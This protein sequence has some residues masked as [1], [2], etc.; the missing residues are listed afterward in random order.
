[1]S[2]TTS[3]NLFD[4]IVLPHNFS[5]YSS[6]I[7]DSRIAIPKQTIIDLNKKVD[8]L[9]APEFRDDSN[10]TSLAQINQKLTDLASTNKPIL[11]LQELTETI[12]VTVDST[13]STLTTF[14]RDIRTDPSNTALG[15]HKVDVNFS[16]DLSNT[17]TDKI[18]L[19][20]ENLNTLSSVYNSETKTTTF[21]TELISSNDKALGIEGASVQFVLED[22][23]IDVNSTNQQT[24]YADGITSTQGIGFK[25]IKVNP[26]LEVLKVLPEHF[27]SSS[28]SIESQNNCIG[29]NSVILPAIRPNH[30]SNVTLN[31]PALTLT[32]QEVKNSEIITINS[33]NETGNVLTINAN[34]DTSPITFKSTSNELNPNEIKLNKPG[35]LD[36]KFNNNQVLCVSPIDDQRNLVLK[37]DDE[38][39]FIRSITI[40]RF[41]VANSVTIDNTEQLKTELQRGQ[42][43]ISYVLPEYTNNIE[44]KLP[45]L[46]LD[47]TL[48]E[49]AQDDLFGCITTV[50]SL[51]SLLNATS[52]PVI[53]GQ[54]IS[55]TSPSGTKVET[56][57]A[58]SDILGYTKVVSDSND[59]TQTRT[60]CYYV[61]GNKYYKKQLAFNVNAECAYLITLSKFINGSKKTLFK[62]KY[63]GTHNID[64]I[65]PFYSQYKFVVDDTCG[66][67]KTTT[68]DENE[69]GLIF[70]SAIQSQGITVTADDN[71]EPFKNKE[72]YDMLIDTPLF[73]TK[74]ALTENLAEASVYAID[75]QR[76]NEVNIALSELT[77]VTYT[78]QSADF[79]A[80]YEVES[81]GTFKLDSNN[82]P[83]AKYRKDASG[84]LSLDYAGNPILETFT[85][86]SNIEIL[87]GFTYA[88][89]NY[90]L[91]KTT[92]DKQQQYGAYTASCLIEKNK[93]IYTY[94]YDVLVYND[95]DTAT[96]R[97]LFYPD[98]LPSEAN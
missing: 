78:T 98:I 87:S 75:C 80:N 39:Y 94:T 64:N 31:I 4:K 66:F 86:S 13:C 47:A 36:I 73:E 42:P 8:N 56:P 5:E 61:T 30:V 43:S 89:I 19:N 10:Y 63:L 91:S 25:N 50:S 34:N 92:V 85:Y 58:M 23:T 6:L 15:F 77:N 9:I 53:S 76:L 21:S 44:L 74:E 26:Q 71:P 84:N 12:T 2:D 7:K 1:M 95:E 46:N 28:I 22:F 83:I 11:N 97:I 59:F 17:V 60:E 35:Y 32:E 14:T 48:N 51:T 52:S 41:V 82:N 57:P 37:A 62:F 33:L 18:N 65:T 90:T 45:A 27:E 79:E 16:L 49:N 67:Y 93:Q 88:G 68:V 55:F 72:L 3:T 69:N 40:P 96:D 38:N 20:I 70:T 81:D 29:Y 24:L 54:T